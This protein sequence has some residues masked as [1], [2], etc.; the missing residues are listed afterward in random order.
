MPP[1][2]S[3]QQQQANAAALSNT[4]MGSFKR[5][6]K[7]SIMVTVMLLIVSILIL[8]F[9]LAATTR[10]QNITVGGYYPGVILGFGSFLGIIGAHLIENKRQMLVASIVFISFGVVAAFCCAIV[11]GVFAASHIDL[12]PLYAGRCDYHSGESSTERDVPCQTSSRI[13]CNLRVKSNTCYCCDLYNCGKASRVEVIGGYHE[14]IDVKSCQDVVHL[15]HLLWSAT[16]LNIVAL[17]LGIITAAVLGGF[18][19]MIPFPASEVCEPEAPPAPAPSEP[20]VPSSYLSSYYN[21]APC[22]PPYTAYDLQGSSTFPD[23]SGLSDESQSGASHMWP[24]MV[25]PRYSPPHFPP[26]EKPPPYSP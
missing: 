22:L 15:Y 25:P 5:R 10:T 21:T 23:S 9:G 14:Y 17:F 24:T 8:I 2:Q 7:K 19:D 18:K 6:K 3:R 1:V 26:D 11:D 12:R 20:S 13:T 4:T 16:I